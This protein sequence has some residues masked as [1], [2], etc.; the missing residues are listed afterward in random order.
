MTAALAPLL[1]RAQQGDPAAFQDLVVA[2]I[3]DV[4]LFIVTYVPTT[5]LGDAVLREVFAAIRRELVRCPADDITGWMCRT[6][7]TLVGMRLAD[8]TRGAVTAKDPLT[9]II[10][11]VGAEALSL[12]QTGANPAAVE[13]PRRLPMQPP[14]LRQLLQRH[15]NE[16]LTVATI[17]EKQGLVESEVAQAL[18]AARARMDWSGVAEVGDTADRTFP[19]VLE[20]FLAGTLVP[21]TRALLVAGVMHDQVRAVQF[22]RQVRLHLLLQVLLTPIDA[23]QVKEFV[24]SLPGFRNES[25]RLIVPQRGS[26]GTGRVAANSKPGSGPRPRGETSRN[27]RQITETGSLTRGFVP[28]GSSATRA[29]AVADDDDF[30]EDAPPPPNRMPL[31]IGGGVAA[32]GL[33]ILVIMWLRPTAAVQ[34]G[35]PTAATPT[36]QEVFGDP[37]FA[38]IHQS[39]GQALIRHAGQTRPA[40][41]GESFSPGDGLELNGTG[42]IGAL[43]ADQVRMTVRPDTRISD[44]AL[45]GQV[46]ALQVT[47]GRVQ[48][49]HRRGPKVT[50]V[51][52]RTPQGLVTLPDASALVEVVDGVTRVQVGRGKPQIAR[53]DGKAAVEG[54]AGGVV[55]VRAGSDPAVDGG[56]SFVRGIRFGEG[57]VT[58]DRNQWISLAEALGGGLTVAAGARVGQPVQISGVGMDFDTK[59][60][61]DTGLV[62]EGGRLSMRQTLP[63]G[64]YDLSLWVAGP[65]DV[66]L[67]QVTLAVAGV[68]VPLGPSSGKS[69]RWRRIGPCRIQVRSRT[70]E[71]ALGGLSNAHLAGLELDAA[72]PLEGTLPPLIL[73]TDPAPGAT[74]PPLDVAVRTRVDAA[75]GIAKVTFFNGDAQIGEATTP[76]YT[77]VWRTPPVGP[78]TLSAVVTDNA[79]VTS[80]S[81]AVPGIVQDLAQSRGLMREVWRRIGGGSI[82]DLRGSLASQAQ[83]VDL[84]P[85][86]D[87]RLSG[88]EI[89]ARFRA[90]L[91]PPSDGDYIFEVVSDDS[92][93]VWLS[94][95]EDPANR[96]LVCFVDGFVDAGQWSRVPSQRSQPIALKG[97]QR[98]FL[99]VLY[100]QGGGNAHLQLGWIR[101]DGATERPIPTDRFVPLVMSS[102]VPPPR[103]IMPDAPKPTTL[104]TT[105]TGKAPPVMARVIPTAPAGPT[106]TGS[107]T[108]S[109][110]VANLSDLGLTDWIH[111]GIT[112]AASVTRRRGGPEQLSV[113]KSADGISRYDNNNTRFGWNDGASVPVAAATNTGWFTGNRGKGF[114]FTAPADPGLRRLM[115]WVGGHDTHGIFTATLSDGSAPAYRDDSITIG[116]GNGWFCYTLLYRAKSIGAKLTI[117]YS[118]DKANDGNITLQ[119]VALTEY[120]DDIPRFVKGI[121]LGGDNATIAGNAWISQKD[122]ETA[123]LVIYNSRR[124]S[125]TGEPVPAAETPMKPMLRSGI[126]AKGGDLEI[127]DRAI[128]NGR[129]EVTLYVSETGAA[130][131]HLFDVTVNDAVLN[132]IGQLPKNGWAAY[133]PLTATVTKGVL[134]II[135]KGKKGAPQL[136]GIA[137]HTA[138]DDRGAWTNAFPAGRAHAIPGS[139]LFADFDVGVNGVAFQEREDKPR[140]PFYRTE[141]VG[142][143]QYN[144]SPVVAYVSEGEWLRYTVNVKE[145]GTY[146]VTVKYAKANGADPKNARVQ[147]EVD[148]AAVG[149]ELRLEDTQRWDNAKAVTSQ[150]FQMTAGIH[151][152]R[153]WFHGE[154][155]EMGDFWSM[156]F[157]KN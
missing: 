129:Y 150:P 103:A 121:N 115:V 128:P 13:L 9:H 55:V 56:G 136:M 87:Y 107:V 100:K 105:P 142:I 68:Q 125:G 46:L 65:A 130:N 95:D 85:N 2:T 45:Q 154:Q 22:E 59:R 26:K 61:L 155:D 118:S 7:G 141:L 127:H 109:S 157:K 27:R 146:T 29:T 48:V 21:D 79:G 151:D 18:L 52:I 114:T 80:R 31:F 3:N 38:L 147:F 137:V 74:I 153:A 126:A 76:P 34:V 123:G 33:L 140:N 120:G 132:D 83:D 102:V 135:A 86:T 156:E 145:P 106:V 36:K 53:L 152:L 58:I 75:G 99:E 30:G 15:Y 35:G 139:I 66:H 32:L 10:A 4:R 24:A 138:G 78:Y 90:A 117:N 47:Q 40:T 84:V 12:N 98:C 43:I 110:Q 62:G 54:V 92:S 69:D 143:N 72:G 60:M 134:S 122:A 50:S 71:L 96:R 112:D 144:G 64:D 104:V 82:N 11:Q 37:S 77:F 8:A 6:A 42:S 88:S 73:L 131:S 89:G 44:I 133:G 81:A 23:A 49:D 67:D 108:P 14:S 116:D 148:G 70:L 124:I 91:L 5:A 113:A 1:E 20:D 63:N 51:A 25:S 149:G 28:A 119:A 39:E 41:S 94:P 16:G 101:P 57:V 17:A 111:Y 19:S 93:E 97:G